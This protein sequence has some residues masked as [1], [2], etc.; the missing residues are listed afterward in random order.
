MRWVFYLKEMKIKSLLPLFL[1]CLSSFSF[2]QKMM[3]LSFVGTKGKVVPEQ[4][5]PVQ[6]IGANWVTLMPFGY[7]S[8]AGDSLVKYDTS[9]QW[10]G[11]TTAGVEAAIPLFKAAKIKVML[12]PQIWI[13]QGVYTGR[14]N[15]SNQHAWEELKASYRDFIMHF[16]RL[17]EK[18]K[19]PLYCI[20]TEL[21][22]MVKED[23][24]F[25][26]VLIREIRTVY[27]GQLV[28]AENW[29]QYQAVPFWDDLDYIGINAYFPLKG[30]PL[31]TVEA[32]KQRW[33]EIS[34]PMEEMSLTF[35]RPILFTEMGYRSIRNP[36]SRPWDYSS[37]Q[38]YNS[39]EQAKALKALLDYF[40]PKSW[41]KGG[42]VWKW[43]PDHI[44]A[45]GKNHTGFS[46]QNKPAQKVLQTYFTKYK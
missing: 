25:W 41:W 40:I 10:Q 14:I 42:F 22:S 24:Q 45:G 39:A 44:N 11:E 3:G 36:L 19:L 31:L 38:I 5:I 12:K 34:F 26:R 37:G 20:G 21:S 2:G 30:E 17:A 15:L 9:W 23:A 46:P 35:D 7:L 43:F 29:D 4:I 16:A 1:L 27:H 8:S 13:S 6:E 18:H 32:I 28:Y 33:E